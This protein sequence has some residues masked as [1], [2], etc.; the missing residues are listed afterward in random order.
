MLNPQQDDGENGFELVDKPKEGNVNEGPTPLPL[1]INPT[2]LPINLMSGPPPLLLPAGQLFPTT[3]TPTV[4]SSQFF[5]GPSSTQH[6]T[7]LKY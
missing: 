6:Q 2:N 1:W 5:T 3:S 4:T 7:V